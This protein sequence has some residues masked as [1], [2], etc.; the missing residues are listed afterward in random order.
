LGLE[1]LDTN[2]SNMP[3]GLV[4][5]WEKRRVCSF[6]LGQSFALNSFIVTQAIIQI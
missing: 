6:K 4:A 5:A 2:T 1:T 3:A